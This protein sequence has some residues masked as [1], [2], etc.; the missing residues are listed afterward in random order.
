V[1]TGAFDHRTILGGH[2]PT[3]DS[4]RQLLGLLCNHIN[5]SVAKLLG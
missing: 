5:G 2:F 1:T 3:G 4:E